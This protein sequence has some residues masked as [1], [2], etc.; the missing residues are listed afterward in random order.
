MILEKCEEE[1][2]KYDRELCEYDEELKKH[3]KGTLEYNEI[4]KKDNEAYSNYKEAVD[5]K[6]ELLRIKDTLIQCNE[7]RI[8]SLSIA[9]LLGRKHKE[10]LKEIKCLEKEGLCD[11]VVF[12]MVSYENS[13]GK[14][15]PMYLMNYEGGVNIIAKFPKEIRENIYNYPGIKKPISLNLSKIFENKNS[16]KKGKEREFSISLYTAPKNVTSIDNV[17]CFND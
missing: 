13:K 6:N 14:K 7:D 17:E 1:I 16:D 12:M 4:V 5:K 8:T 11:E 10:I 3:E 2:L 9:K 15:K